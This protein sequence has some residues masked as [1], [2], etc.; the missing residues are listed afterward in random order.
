MR[1]CLGTAKPQVLLF[2]IATIVSLAQTVA[3][4]DLD[5]ITISGRVIDQNGALIAGATVTATLASI[6]RERAVITDSSGAYR[7]V[8]LAPGIYNV[9]ASAGGFTPEERTNLATIAAQNVALNFIL[10]PASVTA[11]TVVVSA[12]AN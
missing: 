1:C 8:Q 9:K 11:G 5:N 12:D 2:M 4:Q 3:S 10:K 7:L 6:K